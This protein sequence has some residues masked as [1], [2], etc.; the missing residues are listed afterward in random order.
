MAEHFR[1]MHGPYP[2]HDEPDFDHQDKQRL[3]PEDM[4]EEAA[5]RS[6][7]AGPCWFY[8]EE[9]STAACGDHWDGPLHH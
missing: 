3:T 7:A 9:V 5:H 4:L 8:E 6:H 2:D 1:L